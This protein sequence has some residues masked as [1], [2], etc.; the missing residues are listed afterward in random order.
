MLVWKF[1][2]IAQYF[3]RV[4]GESP[5]LYF[6]T[7]FPHQEIK[8]NFGILRN[9]VCKYRHCLTLLYTNLI[10]WYVDLFY[11]LGLITIKLENLILNVHPLL[12]SKS[13]LNTKKYVMCFCLYLEV[14]HFT[15][16]FLLSTYF[17]LFVLQRW[18]APCKVFYT[19]D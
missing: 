15:D 1:C 3:R 4:S 13:C 14:L 19:N 5:E 10:D 11:I 6:S 18:V 12:N 17:L 9:E 7:N 8:W 2:G 16:D